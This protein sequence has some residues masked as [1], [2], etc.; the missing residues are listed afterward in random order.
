[1]NINSKDKA[2]KKVYKKFNTNDND[3]KTFSKNF[4]M[5]INISSADN[6]ELNKLDKKFFSDKT[7]HNENLIKSKLFEQKSEI[8]DKN[9]G[10]KGIKVTWKK[11]NTKEGR[12]IIIDFILSY[13]VI[14]NKHKMKKD[15][16]FK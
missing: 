12:N 5:Q 16:I 13:S 8:K 11:S 3:G 1:M 6:N 7:L 4:Q 10:D 2:K 9:I 15:I 14:G